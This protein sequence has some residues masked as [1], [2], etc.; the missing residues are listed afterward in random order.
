MFTTILTALLSKALPAAA[1]FFM[2]KE[3]LKQE[4]ELEKLR[5]KIAWEEALTRRAEASEGRDHEWELAR[6]KD[7]GWK[8]EWVLALLSVPL[9]L[10]FI[11]T[12]APYVLEGFSVLE[13]T[14]DWYQWLVMLIFTAIYGIRIWRRKP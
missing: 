1:D 13:K 11:P 8:D 9:M 4:V 12:T 5:G 14:P 3:K 2:N 10:V 6:I 7:S